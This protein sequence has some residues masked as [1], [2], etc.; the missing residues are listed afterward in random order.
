ME[1]KIYCEDTKR[2]K[3]AHILALNPITR[4]QYTI[5]PTIRMENEINRSEKLNDIR[6]LY[7]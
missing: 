6:S 5:D 3:G 1:D 2:V 4:K 7:I